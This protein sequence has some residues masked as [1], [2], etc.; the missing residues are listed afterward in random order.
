M[1]N[2]IVVKNVN[3]IELAEIDFKKNSYKFL[4]DNLINDIVTIFK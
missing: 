3:A 2:K 4:E 1:I